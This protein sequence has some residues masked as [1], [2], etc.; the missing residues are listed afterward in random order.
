[1]ANW[2]CVRNQSFASLVRFR[3]SARPE[4]IHDYFSFLSVPAPKSIFKW[5]H[6]L[7]PA[8]LLIADTNTG[9]VETKRYWQ[10]QPQPDRSKSRSYFVEGLR[11][12][13]EESVRLRMR[14]DVPIGALLSGG[15]DST[16][17]V[18]LMIKQPTAGCSTNF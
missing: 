6:K 3:P 14:S 4:A 12:L 18:G 13:L 2:L 9:R 8:H 5:V 15:V 16:A 1:M 11:D 17:V 10:V 7:S